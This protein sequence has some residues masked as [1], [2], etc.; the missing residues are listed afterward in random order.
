MGNSASRHGHQHGGGQPA[1]SPSNERGP[2]P[3][4]PGLSSPNASSSH[5][6]GSTAAAS[7]STTSKRRASQ[8]AGQALSGGSSFFAGSSS[9]HAQTGASD[10]AI[11]YTVTTTASGS[12][13]VRA[14]QP[15]EPP[16]DLDPGNKIA[17]AAIYAQEAR[18]DHGHLLP[19]SNIYP[20]AA[21]DWLH[22]VVQK[23]IVERKLAPFYRG[24]EDYN[25]PD[26]QADFDVDAIDAA[27]NEVGDEQ[28]KKWRKKLYKDADRKAEANM[29]RK[30]SECPICFL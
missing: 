3:S 10:H 26:D 14:G 9:H 21:Q 8:S 11:G 16:K 18:V 15:T 6:A 28:A 17:A 22:D 19:L 2:S 29:Y 24:L 20:N 1:S 4:S 25:E 7:S 27:L 12:R 13:T 5:G 30:A 23:L